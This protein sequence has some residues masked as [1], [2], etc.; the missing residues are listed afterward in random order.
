MPWPEVLNDFNCFCAVNPTYEPMRRLVHDLHACASEDL[1]A[2]QMMG[3]NLLLSPDEEL[4]RND[5]ILLISYKPDKDEFHFEHRT[6]SRN[7]DS[8]SVSQSE[9]WMT[10][11][12]FVG[13]KFGIRL[14]ETRP[15]QPE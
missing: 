4:H 1:H 7:D 8:K 13:Y 14:P 11:R 2:T 3:G 12:L 15:S 6:I 9:A 5:N 10:L